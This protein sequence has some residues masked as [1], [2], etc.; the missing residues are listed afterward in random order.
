MPELHTRLLADVIVLVRPD[1]YI[2]GIITSGT[3]DTS[4]W[5]TAFTAA[6]RAFTPN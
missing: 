4:G 3:S 1:G 2:A 5:A 6:A